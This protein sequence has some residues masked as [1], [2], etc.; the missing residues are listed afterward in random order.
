MPSTLAVLILYV[1][2]RVAAAISMLILIRSLMPLLMPLRCPLPFS[3][4]RLLRLSFRFL[5]L[6]PCC[7]AFTRGY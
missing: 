1:L 2:P 4:F 5:S 3:R 7:C 6:S